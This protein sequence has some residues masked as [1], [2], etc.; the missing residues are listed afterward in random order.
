[1]AC[2]TQHVLVYSNQDIR[3]HKPASVVQ[4]SCCRW[5]V[6]ACAC[7]CV[8]EVAAT[9]CWSLPTA[10]YGLLLMFSLSG[11]PVGK[12]TQGSFM[13][14]G[15][16]KVI[17]ESVLDLIFPQG[18]WKGHAAMNGSPQGYCVLE[19]RRLYTWGIC[20]AA[21]LK[22]QAAQVSSPLIWNHTHTHSIVSCSQY[23]NRNGKLG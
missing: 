20:V 2:Y 9:L 16:E 7:S 23:S 13:M 4:K 21:V 19:K 6:C 17:Q 1:M 18:N 22:R 3:A 14:C 12:E 8:C 10:R 15:K 5:C 11:I